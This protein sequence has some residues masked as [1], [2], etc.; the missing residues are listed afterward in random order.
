MSNENTKKV[1]AI[2]FLKAPGG[3]SLARETKPITSQNIKDYRPEQ[4]TVTK[5]VQ[6]LQELG[7]TV[8]EASQENSKIITLTITG[9]PELFEKVFDVKLKIEKHPPTKSHNRVAVQSRKKLKIPETLKEAVDEI[10]F[11]EPVELFKERVQLPR[12]ERKRL[13]SKKPSASPPKLKKTK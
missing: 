12:I 2:I 7:F 9:Q 13:Y 4:E 3:L 5:A 10:H 1:S 11:E 8:P 6:G